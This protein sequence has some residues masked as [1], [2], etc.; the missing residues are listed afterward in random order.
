MGVVP[1]PDIVTG[2]RPLLTDGL[3][4]ARPR[5]GFRDPQVLLRAVLDAFEGD[6]RAREH[7]LGSAS[8]KAL[9]WTGTPTGVS[10]RHLRTDQREMFIALLGACLGRF[11][12]APPKPSTRRSPAPPLSSFTSAWAGSTEPH[13]PHYYR[14]Q[15]PRLLAEYDNTQR[16]ANNVHTVW[17]DP[18]GD[19]CQRRPR[20]PLRHQPLAQRTRLGCA[21]G[22][23]VR[24][25]P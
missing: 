12:T 9:R 3:W 23:L 2:N 24:R 17:R 25:T 7:A 16:D 22:P 15:G 11:P 6:L 14:I 20:R 13:Q 18:G 1:P 10:W 21:P 8:I 5:E 4:V 19:F